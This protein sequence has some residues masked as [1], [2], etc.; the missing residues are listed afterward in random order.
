MGGWNFRTFS[1]NRPNGGARRRNSIRMTHHLEA[2]V[3]FDRL[4]GRFTGTS[5]EG[6]ALPGLF[7]PLT[8]KTL[9]RQQP[10]RK[11]ASAPV[12]DPSRGSAATSVVEDVPRFSTA[13]A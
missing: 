7:V 6:L 11:S 1:K 8:P 13:S 9:S 3:I 5:L 4:A 10:C 2:A 12:D